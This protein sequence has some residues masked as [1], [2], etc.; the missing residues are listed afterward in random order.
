M[1]RR[2]QVRWPSVSPYW[3]DILADC[4]LGTTSLLPIRWT[5]MKVTRL[6]TVALFTLAGLVRA[7]GPGSEDWV[8]VVATGPDAELETDIATGA[9]TARNG[10]TVRHQEAVLRAQT[11]TLMPDL[12]GVYAEG[13]V[14]IETSEGQG[15]QQLKAESATYRFEDGA[16]SA[17]SFQA[18]QAPYFIGGREVRSTGDGK[19]E[20]TDGVLTT[21]DLEEPGYHIKAKRIIV[22]PGERISA[23]SA[24][25]YAGSVPVFYWPTYSRSLKP[26][27]R[28]WTVLPGYRRLFGPF[29]ETAY[30]WKVQD[31]LHAAMHLD[32]RQRRGIAGGPSFQYDLGTWG[33]GD[34]KFYYAHDENP[35]LN[36]GST[37][38]DTHRH[39]IQYS[40]IYQNDNGLSFKVR[41]EDQSDANLMRDFFE[42][43]YRRDLQPRSFAELHQSWPNW[44]FN[45]LAQP[46]LNSFFQTI[47]RLPDVKLTGL[48]QQ[49]GNTPLFYESDTSVAYL[50]FRAGL[51]GGTDHAAFRGD[52]YHQIVMPQTYFG[53][54]NVIPRVGGRYT[55]YGDPEGLNTISTDQSRWLLNTGTEINFKASR[56]WDGVQSKMFDVDGL[57][58]IVQPSLNYVFVPEPDVRPFQLPQYDFDWMTPRLLP[59]EFPD[60][61][62][63]DSIDS[64]NAIRWGLRN[65]LQTRREG[66]VRDI[67]NWGIQA[68]W[69]IN[70]RSDQR[71]FSEIFSDVD[72]APT[73]WIQL[74]SQ[75][76]YNVHERLWREA[77]HRVTIQPNTVWNVTLGHRYLRD[78]PATYGP[79]NNL[80][81][82]SFYYRVNENW[83][84]RTTHYFETRDGVMEEQSYSIYR[85][86]RSWT[87]MLGVR[88]REN[89]V[90]DDDWALVFSL[91]LKA[92]PNWKLNDDR[93]MP[94]RLFGG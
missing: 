51:L 62:S 42:A 9:T 78:D 67:L 34:F 11:V 71:T 52:S 80:L 64:Q 45:V 37:P 92:F 30:H 54:L 94:E 26:H 86:L 18:G 60:Y 31:S 79:G 89:R 41:V 4:P 87:A 6:G 22:E 19:Y 29:V 16:F 25:V 56:K 82:G 68:D 35:H 5:H 12:S 33:E 17:T 88:I 49:L 53:W 90:G 74:S 59:I 58:H 1:R 91:Q 2:K 75:T 27:D 23:E 38:V 36:A 73:S 46:Q 65:R 32:L 10:V 7:V 81:Y 40:H 66:Q 84:L 50:R 15:S 63:V 28:Y 76:R 3:L 83:G 48:R 70:P 85:D 61:N 93:D 69:R 77:N 20:V 43:T 39:S 55:Y 21:D 14:V 44:T 57:R 13:N 8:D 72:F 47:E 24:T